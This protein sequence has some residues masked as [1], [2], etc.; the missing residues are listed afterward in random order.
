MH[1][2]LNNSAPYSQVCHKLKFSAENRREHLIL[3]IL[4]KSP[5]VTGKT[6]VIKPVH[7]GDDKAGAA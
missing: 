7:L 1:S 6:C 2:G 3:K 5:L 4:G